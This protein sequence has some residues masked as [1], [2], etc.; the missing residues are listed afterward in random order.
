MHRRKKD[1]WDTRIFDLVAAFEADSINTFLDPESYHDLID[2]YESEEQF[3]KALSV[4]R[5][6][7]EHYRFSADFYGRQAQLLL[8]T[9]RTVDAKQLLETG[10]TFTPGDFEL[11]L[12]LC[13]TYIQSGHVNIGLGLLDDLR[14]Q[15]DKQGLSELL[16]TEALAYEKAADYERLFHTLS[17]AIRMDYS[18]ERA[19]ERLFLCTDICRNHDAAIVLY[20]EIIDD[21]PYYSLAWFY[22]GHTYA[23]LRQPANALEAFEYAFLTEPNFEEAYL[24]FAELNYESGH[25]EKALDTYKEMLERFGTDSDVLFRMGSC[26]HHLGQHESA[27]Q[28]LEAAARIEPHNDEVIFRIGQCYAAQ[29]RWSPAIAFFNKAIRMRSDD[30]SYH[31]ALAEAAFEK[32]DFELAEKAYNDAL[33]LAPDNS[34]IWLDLAWFFVEMLRPTDAMVLLSEARDLVQHPEIAYAFSACLFA[35]GRRQEALVRLSDALEDNFEAYPH[36]FEWHPLLRM[37]AEVNALLHIHRK[38]TNPA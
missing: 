8:K 34:E 31:L 21:N 2:F 23:Y 17:A 20:Q 28:Q 9:N 3:E 25:I 37:D 1:N 27:R 35:T 36:L 11:R 15:A 16:L 33:D 22:L 12:L 7:G 4:A 13:E 30:E 10:L 38:D 26:L 29:E 32:E 19:L 24:E 14:P 5:L 18:N 6:A